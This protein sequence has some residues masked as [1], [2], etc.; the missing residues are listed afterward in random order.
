MFGTLLRL[1]ELKDVNIFEYKEIFEAIEKMK[2]ALPMNHHRAT[3]STKRT[4]EISLEELFSE[5]M[6][7]FIDQIIANITARFESN[8]LKFLNC[9]R[10][11]DPSEVT[12]EQQYG[13]DAR[14]IKLNNNIRME[15][16][17]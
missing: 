9:F 12:N 10:V 16:I 8:V 15:S 7:K 11:F 2:T 6:V 4:N 17:S 13:V 5:K 14:L 3:R 1:E